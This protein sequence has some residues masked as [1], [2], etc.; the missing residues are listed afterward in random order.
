MSYQNKKKLTYLTR[1]KVISGLILCKHT[2]VFMKTTE[3]YVAVLADSNIVVCS[4]S[5]YKELKKEFKTLKFDPMGRVKE[6]RKLVHKHR[7]VK[8]KE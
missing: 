8:D 6:D 2:Y 5:D 1:G 3:E 4:N 7:V